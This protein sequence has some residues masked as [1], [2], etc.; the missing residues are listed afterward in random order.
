MLINFRAFRDPWEAHLLR[1]RLETEGI[2]AFVAS[3]THIGNNW[4]ISIALGG[5]RVLILDSQ[6]AEA[7]DVVS[8]CVD[9]TYEAELTEMF[10]AIPF[11]NCPVCG[12]EDVRRRPTLG[13]FVFGVSLA[14]FGATSRLGTSKC[15]CRVC[16]ARWIDDDEK[17]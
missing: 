8:R 14:I 5:A 6:L 9:G 10:G 4:P 1:T 2:P 16:K 11:R 3:D 12:S 13:E 17:K 7:N 15:Y